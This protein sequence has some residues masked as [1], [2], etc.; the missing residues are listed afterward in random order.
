MTLKSSLVAAKII[1]KIKSSLKKEKS[2]LQ[3]SPDAVLERPFLYFCPLQ[4]K[5]DG[6]VEYNNC[7]LIVSSLCSFDGLSDLFKQKTRCTCEFFSTL[8]PVVPITYGYYDRLDLFCRQLCD[9]AALCKSSFGYI[10]I[11]VVDF[12]ILATKQMDNWDQCSYVTDI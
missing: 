4:I 10:P 11:I 9:S 12:I 1:K 8:Y 2:A 7:S 6:G 3:A 5:Q